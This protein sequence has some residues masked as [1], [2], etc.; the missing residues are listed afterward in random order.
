MFVKF[1]YW[2]QWFSISL[3]VSVIQ[4]VLSLLRKT[5]ALITTFI[6]KRK[7]LQHVTFEATSSP[8]LMPRTFPLKMV[9]AGKALGTR[10]L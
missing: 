1:P 9:V 7:L 4:G 10:L 8:D 3:H 2:N 5:T 6:A